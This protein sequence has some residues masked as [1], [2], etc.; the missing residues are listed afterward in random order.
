M[1]Q[2]PT[3][4]PDSTARSGIERRSF[5]K[6][7]GLAATAAAAGT[8]VARSPAA[9]HDPTAEADA[10]SQVLADTPVVMLWRHVSDLPSERR[11]VDETTRLPLLDQSAESLVYDGGSL[12]VGYSVWS[13][14]EPAAPVGPCPTILT[15]TYR[16]QPNPASRLVHLSESLGRA[17]ARLDATQ[18]VRSVRTSTARGD[19]VRFV[20]VHGNES[21]FLGL[22][23]DGD[24]AETRRLREIARGGRSASAVGSPVGELVLQVASLERANHF[25]RDLLGLRQVA[26]D[27]D[28][29]VYD[30][31]TILLVLRRESSANLVRFLARNG[32][33]LGDWQVFH[34]PDLDGT[35]TALSDLGVEFPTGIEALPIGRVAYFADP[36]GHPWVLWQP[37]RA[38]TETG[39]GHALGRVVETTT[40]SR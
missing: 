37:S 5:L 25:Y 17:Q 39:Y 9:A 8:Q 32:R 16:E 36:D 18:E 20:D 26:A 10:A 14:S 6:G 11:F 28:R 38:V 19:A 15:E 33:L 4:S 40:G 35:V 21:S 13:D 23:G 3:R 7:L 12:L 29:A 24:P 1:S 27:P 34:T 30:L 31:G 2:D 22:D